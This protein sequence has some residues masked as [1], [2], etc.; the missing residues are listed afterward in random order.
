MSAGRPLQVVCGVLRDERGRVLACRRP[1]GKALAGLWEFP[2]GK[3]EERER[4][5]QALIR[6]LREEL[7]VEIEITE[8]FSRVRHAY[9]A[10]EIELIPLGARIRGGTL[11]LHEHTD[12]RWL[13]EAELGSV[14]W[15]PA[16]LPVLEELRRA[17]QSSK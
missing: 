14:E 7:G 3:V 10:V 6:E 4:P 2:G 11:H 8:T 15:A 17:G 12:A 13:A 9:P 5:E 1:E 16:D